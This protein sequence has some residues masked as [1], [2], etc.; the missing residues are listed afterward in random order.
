MLRRWSVALVA[1]VLGAGL[2][3]HP[4]AAS[5]VAG[6]AYLSAWDRY[7]AYT[8]AT[9]M[10]GAGPKGAP[11]P[12]DGTWRRVQLD[13]SGRLATST[14]SATSVVSGRLTNDSRGSSRLGVRVSASATARPTA[15]SANCQATY[16]L[17]SG[18]GGADVSLSKTS[19][20]VVRSDLSVSGAY[21]GKLGLYSATG[22]G[23]WVTRPG[24]AI[25]RLFPRGQYILGADMWNRI[26]VPKGTTATRTAR[27]TLS[28]SLSLFPIGT[29]RSRQGGGLS[30]ITV[31]HRDCAHDRVN[32]AL[33]DR[34]A[35][36][37]RRITVDVDGRRRLD[38]T[39]SE[40]DRSGY[41]VSG[42]ARRTYGV[43]RATVTTASGGSVTM[44][45]TSWPCAS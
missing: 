14:I 18:V 10:T 31:G 9:S 4:G 24:G 6:N 7:S 12:D 29:L 21:G 45:A 36:S 37:A 44:L 33:L 35:T 28:A 34:A 20:L 5:A 32:L 41:A 30:Y 23:S 13:R 2:V 15:A 39:G 42:I 16:I 8:C 17:D 11:V 1:G 40:L 43:V 27:A 22:P 25:T 3:L 38:L 19:W 26:Q